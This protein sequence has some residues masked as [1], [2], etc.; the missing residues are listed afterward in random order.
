MLGD[1]V[2]RDCET[3]EDRRRLRPAHANKGGGNGEASPAAIAIASRSVSREPTRRGTPDRQRPGLVEHDRV[4]L[5]EALESAAVLH[6]DAVL[7]QPSGR[8]HLH[9][10]H[11]KAERARTGDDEN[12]NGDG[13]RTMHIAGGGKPADKRQQVP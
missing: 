5:G 9:H 8:D 3:R 7:E 12:R 2:E 4:D 11:R 1:F 10:R 13:H 6:H